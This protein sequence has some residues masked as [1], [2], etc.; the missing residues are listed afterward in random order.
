MADL[1]IRSSPQ[2]SNWAANALLAIAVTL[3]ASRWVAPLF[4]GMLDRRAHR[5]HEA[6]AVQLWDSLTQSQTTWRIGSAED[7]VVVFTDYECPFCRAQ[8]D[9]FSGWVP[10]DEDRGLTVVYRHIPSVGTHPHAVKGA[11]YA[12]CAGELGKFELMH[13]L[14]ISDPR[15]KHADSLAMWLPLLGFSEQQLGSLSRCLHSEAANKRIEVDRAFA[16]RLGVEGTPTNVLR[17]R[18]VPG[19]IAPS[20][21]QDSAA[22]L[23]NRE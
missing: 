17:G 20:A 23:R 10:T 7:T 1:E 8:E 14:L 21:V 19:V 15:W 22:T 13:H 16:E 11:L 4:R 6:V 12:I 9:L 3:L 2:W 18:I 5:A